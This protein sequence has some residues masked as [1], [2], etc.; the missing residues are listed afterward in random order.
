[1]RRARAAMRSLDRRLLRTLRT[2]G[3]SPAMETAVIRLAR[4]GGGG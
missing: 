1:M 3:H 4:A 2:R